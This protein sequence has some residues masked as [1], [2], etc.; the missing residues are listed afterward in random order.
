M[1]V[2]ASTVVRRA[3]GTAGLAPWKSPPTRTSPP[4]AVPEAS[5]VAPLS[6]TDSPS[7]LTFPPVGPVASIVPVTSVVPALPATVTSRALIEPLCLAAMENMSPAPRSTRPLSAWMDPVFSTPGLAVACAASA[8]P[9]ILTSRCPP[10]LSAS[11][12]SLPATIVTMP[13]GAMIEPWLAT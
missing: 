6:T 12:T 11:R 8:E 10:T 2:A 7:T 9:S 4:P 1:D 5:I 3:L 13:C